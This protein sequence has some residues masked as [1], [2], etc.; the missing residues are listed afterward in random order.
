MRLVP[1]SAYTDIDLERYR[2][3]RRARHGFAHFGHYAVDRLIGH[4][5]HEFVVYLHDEPRGYPRRLKPTVD[6][7]HG[8]L[9]DIGGSALHRRVD[10]AAFGILAQSLVARAN[11]GPIQ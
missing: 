7:D 3:F 4:L 6:L 10:G 2:K 11:F 9:D 5:Q 8:A 1:V